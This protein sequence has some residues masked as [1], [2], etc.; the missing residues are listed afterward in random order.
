MAIEEAQEQIQ[1]FIAPR[2][3]LL[4]QQDCNAQL[5]T[6][7]AVHLSFVGLFVYLFACLV[8]WFVGWL[9]G[10]LGGWLVVVVAK[11]VQLLYGQW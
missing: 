4:K 6:Q 10:W 5:S 1:R 11:H 8:G 7:T 2:T 9:V 3:F